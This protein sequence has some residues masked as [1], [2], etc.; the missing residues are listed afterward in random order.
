M[1]DF[2]YYNS[3]SYE[4]RIV[5]DDESYIVTFPDLP[6]CLTCGNSIEE[7]LK[8]A[9]DAKACWIKAA[10]EDGIT[11]KEPRKES[12]SGQ[13]R[14]RMPKELHE[15]LYYTAREQGVSMNAY[16]VYALQKVL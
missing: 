3:L 12:F 7:A 8:N 6:G 13:L 1:K 10:L 11:I 4:M 14:L 15:R 2:D 16:C 9:T 5:P